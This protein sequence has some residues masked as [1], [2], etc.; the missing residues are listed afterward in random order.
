MRRYPPLTASPGPARIPYVHHTRL[1]DGR[2]H[3]ALATSA[4]LRAR[5][6]P[7]GPPA[8]ASEAAAETTAPADFGA[9]TGRPALVPDDTGGYVLAY[10]KDPDNHIAVRGYA[11][12]D[13]LLSGDAAHG[14][15][16]PRTLS[17]C[18]E[19]TPDITSVHDGT[20]EL[21][22]HYRA[23][24]DMHR[25]LRAMLGDFTTDAAH[26]SGRA[27]GPAGQPFRAAGGGGARGV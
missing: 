5:T 19:G 2:F 13:A 3:A 22:G 23:E 25:Q 7:A 8:A 18:A 4:D 26:R 20:V 15:D 14:C 10:E 11:D 21:T 1:G 27:S 16:A 24:C 9:G 12:L 17:R 6:R